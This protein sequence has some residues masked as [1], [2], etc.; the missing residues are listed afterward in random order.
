MHAEVRNKM[1]KKI[2]DKL[3]LKF[4]IYSRF[5]IIFRV[6]KNLLK[7]R[8]EVV[9]IDIGGGR[10]EILERIR[11]LFNTKRLKL[12]SIDSFIPKP[13]NGIT[14]L[15][16]NLIKKFKLDQKAD[17]IISTHVIE[18]I[19]I[20]KLDIFIENISSNSKENA[21]FYIECPSPKTLKIPS[22]NYFKYGETP[23][24]FYDGNNNNKYPHIKPYSPLEIY[25]LFS[26][27]GDFKIIKKGNNINIIP[28]ILSPIIIPL[29]II[30]R[31]NNLFGSV[32]W[33]LVGWSSY[34]LLKKTNNPD[35][36]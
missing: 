3:Y 25:K 18:H 32:L 30:K 35:T 7:K 21:Y 31:D 33:N 24:N 13:K 15:E 23:L 16:K 8:K 17:L 4:P 26:K 6:I 36:I 9:I 14:F 22:M 5:N 29:S 11:D 27:T 2:I 20:N 19:P 10:G 12:I 1:T 28:I 34:V